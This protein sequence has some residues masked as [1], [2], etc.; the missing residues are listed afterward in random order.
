[1]NKLF[2]RHS[3]WICLLSF[4][5]ASSTTYGQQSGTSTNKAL[6]DYSLTELKQK[7]DAATAAK[8]TAEVAVYDQAINLRTEIDA[9]VKAEDFDKANL[10]KEKLTA[11]KLGGTAS[12]SVPS[13][14]EK[15]LTDAI[16][17]AVAE[18]NYEKADAL[19]KELEA[20]KNGTSITTPK[21]TTTIVTPTNPVVTST[22]AIPP[23][24]KKTA[25]R[26]TFQYKR[27][28]W[29]AGI[30]TG[31]HGIYNPAEYYGGYEFEEY[32][33]LCTVLELGVR[34]RSKRIST[35]LVVKL[36]TGL[37]TQEKSFQ[38]S[39]ANGVQNPPNGYYILEYDVT[40][41]VSSIMGL[42]FELS[43]SL[44]ADKPAK[45][46]YA[47]GIGIERQTVKNEFTNG[48]LTF[49]NGMKSDAENFSLKSTN[50]T[51]AADLMMGPA[52]RL[53]SNRES[54]HLV[55]GFGGSFFLTPM[56]ADSGLTT[57]SSGAFKLYIGI[58]K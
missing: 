43:N 26:D 54:A 42:K 27:I 14:R 31:I 22:T 15:E 56:S 58:R 48:A 41:K 23:P 28:G 21:P 33:S 38:T 39:Y 20:L 10:L 29:T 44:Y 52:F 46:F 9:A 37:N 16:N 57:Q 47:L 17:K 11:L 45:F 53:G 25:P 51:L 49:N 4:F 13:G 1:M 12:T 50:N 36:G 35:G 19:K 8:A 55:I 34:K 40:S 24:V 5:L 7:R 30:T 3:F 32:R 2:T 6:K 18:E